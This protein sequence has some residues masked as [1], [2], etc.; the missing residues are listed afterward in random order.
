MSRRIARI[1]IAALCLAQ[2]ACVDSSRLDTGIKPNVILIVI[3][4]L[5]SDHLGDHG[6]ARS[7]DAPLQ[8]FFDHSTAFHRAYSPAPWTSPS[9]ASLFTGLFTTRHR[10]NA[11]GGRLPEAAITLAEILAERGW[12]TAAFSFNHNVS[13]KTGFEQ[14]FTDFDDFLGAAVDYPDMHIMMDRVSGWLDNQPT[15]PFF[16]YLQP[17]NVHGPYRTPESDRAALLGSLPSEEFVFFEGPMRSILREHRIEARDRVEQPYL[18]SLVDQYDTAI[19]YSA[20]QIATLLKNLK[21][22][23]L[24]DDAL[25]IITSD[26]G[27]ELF[28]HGGFSHGYTLYE[29]ALGVPLFVKLPGQKTS[30]VVDTTVSLLDLYPTI[31][32]VTGAEA[33]LDLDGRSLLSLMSGKSLRK[34]GF[35]EPRDLFFH[36]AWR[37]RGSA[38]AIKRGKYKFIAV[39]DSY[40]GLVNA[41]LLFDLESDPEEVRDLSA[42]NPKLSRIHRQAVNR[43]RKAYIDSQYADPENIKEQLNL[44]ALQALGYVE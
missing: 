4:T 40:D 29:E 25:I 18:Q 27:E 39:G 2:L 19:R 21:R 6:Y 8:E 5:R 7:T 9:I 42:A 14:G 31:L 1:G 16:M 36:L 41:E 11:H 26:H 44:E 12:H 32:E 38:M 20:Q 34:D 33:A 13:R 22:R 3:D 17:M 30:R 23:G 24:Y 15:T 37:K 43:K 35:G 28:D 10:T